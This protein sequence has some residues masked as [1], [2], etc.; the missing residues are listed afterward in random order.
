MDAEALRQAVSHAGLGALWVG[1]ATGF[2]FSFNPVALAAIPVSLA[3]VTK[4]RSPRQGMVFGGLFILGML[5]THAALGLLAGLGGGWVQHLLGRAWSLALGPWLII[6]GL[7]W[8]G[9]LPVS[10]PGLQLRA[11]PVKG[12]W[13]AFALGVPFSIAICPVCTPALFVLLG[14][15]VGVSSPAFGTILLLAFALGRA[16]PIMLGALA[17]GWLQEL[18]GLR[19]LQRPTEVIGGLLLILT[20]LYVLNAYF[21][22]VPSLAA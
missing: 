16:I 20:G 6:M 5:F 15:A 18:S 7:I 3:Y 9:W 2:V 17:A 14:A 13:A 10:P 11:K 1:L 21:L 22:I 12:A 8:L 4:A 19:R